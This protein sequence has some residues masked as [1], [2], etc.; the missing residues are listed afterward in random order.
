[1]RNIPR[2]RQLY[3]TCSCQRTIIFQ[4]QNVTLLANIWFRLLFYELA[5]RAFHLT[6]AWFHIVNLLK[7]QCCHSLFGIDNINEAMLQ[8][9]VLFSCCLLMVFC[10]FK[11]INTLN[12][13]LL[14]RK[15]YASNMIWFFTDLLS[16]KLRLCVADKF[17][18]SYDL[19][20]M[21][22]AFIQ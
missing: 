2:R 17:R 10:K 9:S 22:K 16:F 12:M 7:E 3:R 18:L 15:I 20:K 4:C 19:W 5:V 1:M 21:F 14:W 8:I 6:I 11:C 13:W